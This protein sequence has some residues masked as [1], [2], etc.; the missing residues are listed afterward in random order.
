MKT[1]RAAPAVVVHLPPPRQDAPLNDYAWRQDESVRALL[2]ALGLKE[3]PDVAPAD[4][5]TDLP[6]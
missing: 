6:D 1:L 3:M 4:D 5:A 2:M